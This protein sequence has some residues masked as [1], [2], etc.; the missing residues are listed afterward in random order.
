MNNEHRYLIPDWPAPARVKACVTRRGGGVSKGNFSSFNLGI[1]SGDVP[2]RVLANRQQMREDFGWSIEPQWLNQVHGTQVVKA[3][4]SG[5]EQE[6]DAVW[7]DADGM[8]CTVLTADCLPVL[9]CDRKGSTIAAA[10]AGWKGLLAG[11]LENTLK[12]MSCPAS[13]VMVWLGP[14]ISQKHF[15]VGPEVRSAFLDIDSEAEA[16]FVSGTGD[17][18]HGDLYQLARQRLGAAGI[19]A[20]YGGG[21]CTFEQQ[22][23]FFS[24]R[25]DG[26]QSGR[27]ASVIWLEKIDPVT[28]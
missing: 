14:A 27:L 12:A 20:I 26:K 22:Q 5:E 7:T 18:W 25:R 15:E 4:D 19:T 11:V 8:P 13:E 3:S 21:Y 1:R 2:E 28:I 9:F 6:G 16:A 23:T 17:R 24:Y 10:H